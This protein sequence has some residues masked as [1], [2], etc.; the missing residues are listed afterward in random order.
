MRIERKINIGGYQSM[1]F[2]SSEHETI[3]DCARDLIAQM[4]PMATVYPTIKV[5]ADEIRKAYQV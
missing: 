2:A 4:I 3:Q 1:A 5:A